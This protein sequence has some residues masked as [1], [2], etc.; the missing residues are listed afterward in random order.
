MVTVLIPF[1]DKA[2]HRWNA[3]A[4][5]NNS[6]KTIDGLCRD[7]DAFVFDVDGTLY[8]QMPVRIGMAEKDQIIFFGDRDEKDGESAALAAIDYLNVKQLKMD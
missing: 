7:Y 2:V 4:K 1:E 8:R 6:N 5:M 3:G